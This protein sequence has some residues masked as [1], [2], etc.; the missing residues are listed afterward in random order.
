MSELP[1]LG[2]IGPL[3]LDLVSA[4]MSA[5]FGLEYLKEIKIFAT[6][7]KS[8]QAKDWD[9]ISLRSKT[10]SIELRSSKMTYRHV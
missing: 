2:V 10:T 9:S 7:S 5:T 4:E 1:I 6:N 3:M 8:T